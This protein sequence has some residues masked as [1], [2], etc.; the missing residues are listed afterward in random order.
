MAFL[1]SVGSFVSK[2]AKKVGKTVAKAAKDTAKQTVRSTQDVAGFVDKNK[3]ILAP[4]AAVIGAPV[5][6]VAAVGAVA[7]A[8]KR[9]GNLG[10]AARGAAVAGG[11]AAATKS[12]VGLVKK[13]I[14]GKSVPLDDSTRTDV[15]VLIRDNEGVLRRSSDTV[16]RVKPSMPVLKQLPAPK[17][18]VLSRPISVGTLPLPKDRLSQL[19][20]MQPI[21]STAP[22]VLRRVS[23]EFTK[24]PQANSGGG[25]FR[26]SILKGERVGLNAN[27]EKSMEPASAAPAPAAPAPEIAPMESVQAALTSETEEGGM[28]KWLPLI[29]IVLLLIGLFVFG[30]K[31]K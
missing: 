31:N 19:L 6:A 11:T 1:G 13:A 8:T 23:E 18:P 10:S 28:K 7:G 22:S 30:R 21:K 17:L 27:R 5:L 2:T 12:V 14:P 9:G 25:G 15:D 20:P 16:Q 4:I 3:L 26:N 29:A 24:P